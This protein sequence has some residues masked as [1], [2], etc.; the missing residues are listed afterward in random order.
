MLSRCSDSIRRSS[1]LLGAVLTLGLTLNANAQAAKSSAEPGIVPLQAQGQVVRY[2][3]KSYRVHPLA[4]NRPGVDRHTLLA[5]SHPAGLHPVK[6]V[7]PATAAAASPSAAVAFYPGDMTYQGG[8]VVQQAESHGLYVNC[9]P[10]C[11]GSPALFLSH[12]QQSTF[13]H[14]TDQYVGATGDNRYTV[15]AGG[16]LQYPT[17]A[18]LGDNDL[19]QIVYAGAS[20][21]GTGYGHIYHIFL[22]Q[23]V[24]V[25]FTGSTQCY[26]PDNPS[27]FAFCAFH[28]SVD[29]S[30]IGH[31]LFTVIPF[32]NVPGCQVAKPSP[33]G[34][35]IDSTANILNHELIETITDPDGDAW[36]VTNDLDLLFGEIGDI[37]ENSSFAYPSSSLNNKLYQ[38]QPEY[39]NNDHA[40]MYTPPN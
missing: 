29:F 28:A 22:P 27:T 26:S 14:V 32:Q 36:W 12:L 1:A 20:V 10:G 40:C 11:W 39:S 4:V 34:R 7:K 16:S 31:V 33:N 21:F 9:K 23:G 8:Q 2:D 24:D 35:L 13:I 38:I 30:D 15:G 37:C 25:C 19:L 5:N 6:T 3:P 18:P 17:L